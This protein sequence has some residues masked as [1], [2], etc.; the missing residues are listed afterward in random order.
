MYIYIIYIYVLYI[1]IYIYMQPSLMKHESYIKDTGDFF[2]KMK[3][4]RKNS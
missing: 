2:K 1:Y 3:G 4:S